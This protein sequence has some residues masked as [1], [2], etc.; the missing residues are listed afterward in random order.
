MS[1]QETQLGRIEGKLDI[2]VPLVQDNAHRLNTV[3]KK[4]SRHSGILATI[5]A[6]F[7]A[8]FGFLNDW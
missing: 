7:A 3:E 5:A 4:V 2:I 6:L 1:K 8:A